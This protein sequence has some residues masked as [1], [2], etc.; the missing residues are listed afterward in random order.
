MGTKTGIGYY[1]KQRGSGNYTYLIGL[2]FRTPTIQFLA[3]EARG[4]YVRAP[5]VFFSERRAEMLD[6]N[7]V[8]APSQTQWLSRVQEL[9]PEATLSPGRNKKGQI[10]YYVFE[11]P[12]RS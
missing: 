8:I 2:Y 3:P 9:Y 11:F 5:E 4:E 6:C 10:L 1:L 12:A 7:I